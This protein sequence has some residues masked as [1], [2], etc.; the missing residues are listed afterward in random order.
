[1]KLEPRDYQSKVIEDVKAQWFL[2]AKNVLLVAPTG[3]GK[4]LIKAWTAEQFYLRGEVIVIFAHRDVLLSQI[5]LSLCKIGL[6]HKFVCSK[7]AER[8]ISNL[9][10]NEFGHSYISEKSTVIIA[11]VQTWVN[12]DTSMIAPHVKL[13]MLDEAHHLTTGTTWDKCVSELSTAKGMGVTATPIRADKKPLGRLAGGFFDSMSQTPGMGDLIKNGS[14]SPYIVYSIP[15]NIDTTNVNITS[16]GDYNQ[17]KLAIATHNADIV[18]DAVSHYK[19]LTP[20]EQ[21]ITFCPSIAY[22]ES[23]AKKFNDAG[24]KAIALS[25]K[26]PLTVRQK[27]I[28]QFKQGVIQ[29]IV[30]V[31]LFGEGFDTPACSVVIMLRKTKSYGLFMQMFGRMLRVSQG[32][33]HGTLIDHVGNVGELCVYGKPHESPIWSLNSSEL[34]KA[35]Y[36]CDEEMVLNRRCP[37]CFAVYTPRS[38]HPNSYTCPFCNH[39]ET[40]DEVQSA[41][42]EMQVSDGVLVE[43]DSYFLKKILDKR[44]D[45]DKP[46]EQIAREMSNAPPI[47]RNS[48]QK[49]HLNRAESQR[50]LRCLIQMWCHSTSL[51]LGLDFQTTQSEFSRVFNVDV[52][53]AQTLPASRADDL[54]LT[55]TNSIKKKGVIK[56]DK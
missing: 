18:G 1:M 44:S 12:R 36:D 13:W 48:A 51:E 8:D 46:V 2:G 28:K 52:F 16:S 17:K 35:N 19:R 15:S 53:T 56:N 29:N 3:A 31:D 49:R 9:Q 42:R 24:V 54:A 50:K 21:A 11:S 34:K 47:V 30:N 45:V 40:N 43:Y 10:V 55:I 37:E 22:A 38:K 26:T 20:G 4:T 32:K 14:L 41:R 6:P 25:S 27:Y 33:E 23:V 39:C 5:S 7:T